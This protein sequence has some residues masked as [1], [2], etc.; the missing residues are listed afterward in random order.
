MTST[1]EVDQRVRRLNRL[2][3]LKENSREDEEIWIYIFFTFAFTK[4][5]T[6]GKN[7]DVEESINY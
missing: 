1:N 2:R 3:K 7:N 4:K 5:P 6:I